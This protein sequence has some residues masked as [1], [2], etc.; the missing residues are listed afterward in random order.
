MATNIDTIINNLKSFYDFS[1]KKVIHVVAG[2]GQ[3]IGYADL[4][5]SVF[6]VD[7]EREAVEQLKR[8]LAETS[9]KHKFTISHGDF[10]SVTNKADVVFFELCLH[11]MDRP[12]EALE[13]ASLLAPEILV[14]DHTPESGWAWHI[15]EEE[16]ARR[17]WKAV[18]FLAGVTRKTFWAQQHFNN[19]QELLERVKVMGE[20]AVM[21][22]SRYKG[23]T[24]IEIE[25]IYTIALVSAAA[26]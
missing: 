13:H 6:C 7:N 24:N 4:A 1:G 3:L 19:H 2:G 15:C 25:M 14:L 18:S 17:S 20:A 16:K 9:F 26:T 11:E 12:R 8:V 23:K 22:A 21:R 10:L 5:G